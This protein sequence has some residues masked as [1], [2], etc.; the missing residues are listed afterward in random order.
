MLMA[1]V[2]VLSTVLVYMRAFFFAPL[3]VSKATGRNGTLILGLY[4]ISTLMSLV[5]ILLSRAMSQFAD[6]M[7]PWLAQVPML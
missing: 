2:F 3:L 6:L 4:W 1:V 5:T 7:Q